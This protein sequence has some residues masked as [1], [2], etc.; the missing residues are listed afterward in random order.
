MPSESF[1]IVFENAVSTTAISKKGHFHKALVYLGNENPIDFGNMLLTNHSS[2]YVKIEDKENLIFEEQNKFRYSKDNIDKLV[3]IVKLKDLL[4]SKIFNA[5][6][7]ELNFYEKLSSIDKF[8]D[9]YRTFDFD[10]TLN[11][12]VNSK[13]IIDFLSSN[14]E[15]RLSSLPIIEQQYFIEDS[16][17]DF[18]D[19]IIHKKAYDNLDKICNSKGKSES[20]F[21]TYSYVHLRAH[22]FIK[23]ISNH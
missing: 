4:R 1:S 12:I 23:N 22:E 11:Q 18:E 9:I 13:K 6:S 17:N 7:V 5:S 3:E 14:I 20:G 2:F 19:V 21:G 10:A 16:N 8:K 15:M